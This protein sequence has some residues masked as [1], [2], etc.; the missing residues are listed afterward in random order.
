MRK[1]KERKK[2]GKKRKKEEGRKGQGKKERGVADDENEEKIG[3]D[4]VKESGNLKR[5]RR[6]SDIE[7]LE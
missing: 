4:K 2:K 7:T 6:E 5:R 3:R 1:K